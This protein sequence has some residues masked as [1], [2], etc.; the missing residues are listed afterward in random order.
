MSSNN[1]INLSF[2]D[3][4]SFKPLVF[5]KTIKGDSDPKMKFIQVAIPVPN[6][7]FCIVGEPTIL[8]DDDRKIVEL[9][10]IVD[11]EGKSEKS[12]QMLFFSLKPNLTL[13]KSDDSEYDLI[14]LVKLKDDTRPPEEGKSVLKTIDE[15]E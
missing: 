5:V 12:G 14:V 7:S 6:S 3:F 2:T 15:D 4:L 8:R 11:G 10:I 13:P 9:T 1:Q